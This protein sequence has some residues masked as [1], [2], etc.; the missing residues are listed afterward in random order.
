[1]SHSH[2][3]RRLTLDTEIVLGVVAVIG[4]M[5][6]FLLGTRFSSHVYSI[7]LIGDVALVAADHE[8]RYDTMKDDGHGWRCGIC[9][10]PKKG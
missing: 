10:L 8:H 1:M 9:G 3:I 7:P 5:V 6:G 4:P 2:V